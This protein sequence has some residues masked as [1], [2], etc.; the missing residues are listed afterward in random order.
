MFEPVSARSQVVAVTSPGSPPSDDKDHWNGIERD[1][2]VFGAL[3][4]KRMAARERKE[5]W[6]SSGV[7]MSGKRRKG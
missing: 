1:D 7:E 5:T 4:A 3:M 6:R 2:S